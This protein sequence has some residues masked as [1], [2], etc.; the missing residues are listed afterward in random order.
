MTQKL[1]VCIDRVVPP[2]SLKERMALV[3]DATWGLGAILRV[4]FMNGD[5]AVR[6]RVEK[7]AQEWT[8]HANVTLLFGDD[9][10]A[11]IRISFHLKGSWSFIGKQAKGIPT[12]KPTMNYGWLTSSSTDDEVRRVVLHEFGH[13]LGC[14][15]EHQNP[16]G[17]IQWNKP[18]V[19]TYFAGPPNKWSPEQVDQNLFKPYDKDLTVHTKLD[20]DSIMMYPIPKAFTLDGF[21]VGM[22]KTL[23]PTD[24]SF[25]SEQYS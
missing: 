13:A 8:N 14:I 24:I 19:Y 21:E 23:S 2:P 12:S 17:G 4:M 5:P 16:A 10:D 25:I 3:K 11:D 22:N 9:P 7:Q 15:H 1:R 20:R 18:A 6:K